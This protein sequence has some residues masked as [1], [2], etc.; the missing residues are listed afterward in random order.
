MEITARQIEDWSREKS[1]QAALPR[2]IRRLIHSVGS[3]TQVAIPAGDSTSQP[4][5]DG[6]LLSEHGNAWVPR[7]R[8]FWELSCEAQVTSKA[9]SDYD[10]RTKGTPEHVRRAGTL[11]IVTAKRWSRKARWLAEKLAA[12]EWYGIRAYDADDIEQWMEQAPA[13]KLQFGDEI[14]VTGY[15]VEDVQRHWVAWAEQTDTVITP[16]AIF[17]GRDAP[18]ERFLASVRRRMNE[19]SAEP[20]AIRADS[21]EEAAAFAAAALLEQPDLCSVAAVVTDTAGWR[22]VDQNTSLRVAIAARPEIAEKPT[23]RK[24]TVVVLPYAAGDMVGHFKGAAGRED[25]VEI[26]LDRPDGHEFE[27]ALVGIGLDE[28]DAKRLAS[29]TGRSWSVFRR[30]YAKNPSIR[31]PA[32]LEAPQASALS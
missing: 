31:R 15:G 7:G 16:E 4:G 11:V 23:I 25:E 3:I 28:G 2:Y 14:G 9:N 19:Q 1:A 18:R 22:F 8:S 29:I 24:G 32:W 30:R 27:R 10:K 21:V 5:W 13:V 26:I 6:E 20:L 12:S 17:V